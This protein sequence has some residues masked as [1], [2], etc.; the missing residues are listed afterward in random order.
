MV[1]LT[2][3]NAGK[4]FSKVDKRRQLVDPVLLGVAVVIH[5]DEGDVQRVGVAVD[6]L[7]A[8][9]HSRARGAV[10]RMVNL[11]EKKRSGW[12]EFGN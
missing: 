7:E 2:S 5:L 9:Q 11:N 1:N 8:L 3:I 6:G 12:A 4:P 10:V